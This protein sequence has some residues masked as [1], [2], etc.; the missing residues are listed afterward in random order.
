MYFLPLLGCKWAVL[1][2][3]AARGTSLRRARWCHE[4]RPALIGAPGQP[5]LFEDT[6]VLGLREFIGDRTQDPDNQTGLVEIR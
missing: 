4:L 2:A 3:A 5:G 1:G 6:S